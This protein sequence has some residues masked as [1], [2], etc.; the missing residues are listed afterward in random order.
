[1]KLYAAIE[2]LHW[3]N[4]KSPHVKYR[5]SAAF[6]PKQVIDTT[7]LFLKA[8]GRSHKIPGKIIYPMQDMIYQFQESGTITRDQKIYLVSMMLDHWDQLDLESRAALWI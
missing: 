6:D 4:L 5:L 1:M 8:I 2:E 3:D 7:K